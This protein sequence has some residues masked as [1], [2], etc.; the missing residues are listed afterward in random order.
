MS[1]MVFGQQL[2]ISSL[3]NLNKYEI[4]PAVAGSE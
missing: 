1:G 4:N 3:Y 2:N